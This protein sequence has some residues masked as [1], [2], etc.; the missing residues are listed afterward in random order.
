MHS[1][2]IDVSKGGGGYGACSMPPFL[3][4]FISVVWL[5]TQ[6]LPYRQNFDKRKSLLSDFVEYYAYIYWILWN[7][8]HTSVGFCGILRVPGGVQG[9]IFGF[10]L[11]H[12]LDYRESGTFY[13]IEKALMVVRV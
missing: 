12:S 5:L 13:R 3:Q 11:C 9:Q 7:I 2:D 8:T 6:F 10:L 1:T 4:K